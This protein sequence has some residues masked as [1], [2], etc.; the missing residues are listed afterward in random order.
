MHANQGPGVGWGLPEAGDIQIYGLGH[1]WIKKGSLGDR[2]WRAMNNV[3]VLPEDEVLEGAG[4]VTWFRADAKTGSGVVTV[5][6]DGVYERRRRSDASAEGEETGAP[7]RPADTAIRGLRAFGVDYSGRAGAP[8]V[9]A[10][11]DK[12]EGGRTKEWVYHI[13][14]G[15]T[16]DVAGNVL[17]VKAGDRS[18]RAVFAA[19]AVVRNRC[20][21]GSML[22]AGGK[23]GPV[24]LNRNA[25]HFSGADPTAGEFFVVVTLQRGDAPPIRV[26]GSGL[27]AKVTAGEQC[28][29]FDGEKVVFAR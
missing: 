24:S 18:M 4:R 6:L 14:D 1:E 28:I 20:V 15:K 12:V 25:I 5:N 13:P 7:G 3:V 11:V 27:D 19:P 9:F 29:S 21:A 17:T 2:T 23:T 16:A 10:I 8:A 26:E 22:S